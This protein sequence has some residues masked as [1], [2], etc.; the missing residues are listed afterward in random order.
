MCLV[1][2]KVYESKGKLEL[3]NFLL[4]WSGGEWIKQLGF[5]FG[6][7]GEIFF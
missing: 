6:W 1:S 3:C 5:N 2:K 4:W 7:V